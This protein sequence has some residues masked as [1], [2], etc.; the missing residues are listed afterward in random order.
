MAATKLLTGDI[1][2]ISRYILLQVS[3]GAGDGTQSAAEPHA[4]PLQHLVCFFFKDLF[5]Y[6][7]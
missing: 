3:L 2:A 4:Q 1:E 6:S 5:I 7:M